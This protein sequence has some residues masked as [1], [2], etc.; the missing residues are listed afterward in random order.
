MTSNHRLFQA[1]LPLSLLALSFRR[2]PPA[3]GSSSDA[4]IGSSGGTSGTVRGGAGEAW[5]VGGL[6]EEKAEEEAEE[7]A[8]A[9][10]A[11]EEGPDAEG[12]GCDEAKV[13]AEEAEEVGAGEEGAARS[14]A[15]P[16]SSRTR[17]SLA[18]IAPAF[19]GLA[20]PRRN[21]FMLRLPCCGDG[22]DCDCGFADLFGGA[23]CCG[24][25]VLETSA[26]LKRFLRYWCV[27]F[28]GVG[29]SAD[30]SPHGDADMAEGGS[31]SAWAEARR[32]LLGEQ[33]MR[34]SASAQALWGEQQI[35]AGSDLGL[36]NWIA[37]EKPFYH[38][39]SPRGRHPS[40][41]LPQRVK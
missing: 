40:L 29:S 41:P 24:D 37:Q 25:G 13:E 15:A 19:E 6:M 35:T 31:F 10:A 39:P 27:C 12:A 14:F 23:G 20:A 9:A 33:D 11:K 4:R 34:E 36:S 18:M 7:E 2:W 17:F 3:K 38:F 8:E 26:R 30:H 1:A 21:S 22:D 16:L 5:C 32:C 28:V